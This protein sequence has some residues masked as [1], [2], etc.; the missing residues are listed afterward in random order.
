ML[1]SESLLK[2]AAK[3]KTFLGIKEIPIVDGKVSFE[4]AHKKKLEEHLTEATTQ[5]RI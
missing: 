4:E 5:Q 1:K 3:I 2:A